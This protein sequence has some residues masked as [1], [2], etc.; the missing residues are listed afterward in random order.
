MTA[1]SSIMRFVAVA[2]AR[3]IAVGACGLAFFAT[4]CAQLGRPSG[5]RPSGESA[6]VARA[7]SN[8]EY[9]PARA[10]SERATG[11]TTSPVRAI[12]AFVN[13]YINWN[14]ANVSARL[15]ALAAQ[16]IGQ[17]RSAMALA[18]AQAAHDY[19]LQRGGVANQGSVEAVAPL[20]GRPNHYVVVTR[21]L[22]TATATDAYQGL[23]PAWHVALA[24]VARVSPSRWVVS[25]W[26]PEN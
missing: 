5:E 18:A 21:E 4:G 23:E 10:P 12:R 14:S 8:H 16:S 20:A 15:R 22:T 13:S 6:G 1:A 9:P 2:S 3:L 19:E 11:G 7:E 24:T 25:G 26:Q 17:A